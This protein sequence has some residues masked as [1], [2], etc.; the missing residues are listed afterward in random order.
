MC[1][2]VFNR[3]EFMSYSQ[4]SNNVRDKTQR[5]YKV[6]SPEKDGKNF[7]LYNKVHKSTYGIRFER[8]F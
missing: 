8:S 3:V 1:V 7:I 2:C 4:L 6:Q 5:T